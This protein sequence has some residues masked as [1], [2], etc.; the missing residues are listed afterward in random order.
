VVVKQVSYI[1]SLGLVVIIATVSLSAFSFSHRVSA[2]THIQEGLTIAPVRTELE[3]PPGTVMS[4][5]VTIYNTTTQDMTVNMSAEGFSVTDIQYDYSFDP[6]SALVKW[7][8]F[9]TDTFTL[10]PG[11]SQTV[12]Y[13]ISVP[14][15]TEPRGHYISLF[16]ST[17]LTGS[18]GV[19]SQERVASLLYITVAGDVTMLG[20]LLSLN[21]PWITGGSASWTATVQ[22]T[23]TTHFRTTY[24]LNVK[25]LW[26]STVA[27]TSRNTLI[28]PSSVR[29][30]EDSIPHVQLPG[31]YKL[32][33]DVTMGDA[34]TAHVTHYILYMPSYDFI[35]IAAILFYIT[36]LISRRVTN[37]KQKK[38]EAR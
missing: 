37:N 33:Y 20:H 1:L 26:D 35:I 3:I 2:A 11:K 36:I 21:T 19:A 10:L 6:G 32:V 7:V 22:N 14:I 23:G 24:S 17:T 30:V 18:G 27:T 4:G 13:T 9:T 12:G 16:A 25:T 29:L 34:P 38:L 31:I 28:L 5:N 8:H 15:G